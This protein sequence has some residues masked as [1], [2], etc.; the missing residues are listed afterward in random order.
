M[1]PRGVTRALDHLVGR[2]DGSLTVADGDADAPLTEVD[3]HRSHVSPRL[4]RTRSRASSMRAG[5]RPPARASSGPL[6]PPP[7]TA[8]AGPASSSAATRPE[9]LA[10][11]ATSATRLASGL[12]AR[13]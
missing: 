9:S 6:P 11:A 1:V 5:S 4:V 10:T 12:P 3:P 2:G 13:T 7:P 8:R